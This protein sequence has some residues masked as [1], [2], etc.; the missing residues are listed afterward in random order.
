MFGA[1]AAAATMDTDDGHYGTAPAPRG[2]VRGAPGAGWELQSSRWCTR[3]RT[4][5][6]A[7][8]RR[9]VFAPQGMTRSLP[10]M[11]QGTM[12]R[13]R[14]QHDDDDGLGPLPQE[15][16]QPL[17]QHDE[18]ATHAQRIVKELYV[19][20]KKQ[21][22]RWRDYRNLFFFLAF[23]AL[24]LAVLYLQRQA[25]TAYQVH[26]TMNDV[27][28]PSATTMSSTDDV[29]AWLKNLLQVNT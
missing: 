18:S 24:Y 10:T 7:A 5:A 19:R 11:R 6:R 15:Q 29:Y 14:N 21:M 28:V 25:N 22:Q 27:L 3:A 9:A 4:P 8:P 1:G 17:Q 20:Y 26:A 16:Q 2:Q 12:S 13:R 23:L